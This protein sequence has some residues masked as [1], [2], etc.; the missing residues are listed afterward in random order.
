MKNSFPILLI[1]VSIG[2]FYLYINPQYKIVKDLRAEKAGYDEV[3]DK[4]KELRQLRSELAEKYGRISAD[5]LDTLQ[6]MIP[7]KTDL[8]RLVLEIDN[9]ALKSGIS[10]KGIKASEYGGT[11]SSRRGNVEA[12]QSTGK[13]YK[14]LAVTFSWISKYDNVTDFL[15]ELE[16]S[17]KIIDI[18]SVKVGGTGAKSP[19]SKETSSPN[20][21]DYDMTIHTYWL[22]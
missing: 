16:T 10:I 18:V 2:L 14:T 4:S 8:V 5:D 6:K 3:L 9:I 19:S 15:R 13:K 1:I 22:N 11:Q 20:E 21:Q 17:L 12:D 7:E